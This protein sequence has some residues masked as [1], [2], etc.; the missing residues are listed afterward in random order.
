MCEYSHNEIYDNEHAYSYVGVCAHERLLI[1]RKP[2]Q[3]P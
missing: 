2:N 3:G 1:N